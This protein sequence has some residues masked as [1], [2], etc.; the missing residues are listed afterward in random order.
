MKYSN[1]VRAGLLGASCLALGA[2]LGNS[3][4]A[5]IGGGGG[6]GGGKTP[7]E[8]DAKFNALTS[9]TSGLAPTS[10]E[11]TGAA[12]FSGV[13]RVSLTEAA[14]PSNTGEAFADL[15]VQ[16]D[17]TNDTIAGQ[18]TNFEGTLNGAPIALIGTL[19]SANSPVASVLREQVDPIILPPGIPAIPGAP[20]SITSNVFSLNMGGELSDNDGVIG[21]V[22]MSMGGSFFG[23]IG[24][25]QATAAVGAAT[26]VVSDVAGGAGLID[27]GGAGTYYIER[28]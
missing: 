12:T 14:N 10:R 27:I 6:G 4:G 26:V 18:A 22:L 23:P 21:T 3:N 7:A 2:C 25:N 13:A 28:D 5:A 20:T 11:L 17:F 1:L 15:A 8:Y 24:G 16:A 19:D 9:N